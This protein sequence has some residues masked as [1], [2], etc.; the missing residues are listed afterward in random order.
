MPSFTFCTDWFRAAMLAFRPLAMARPAAS[1]APLLMREPEDSWKRGFCRLVLVMLTWFCA[2]SEEMLL[3]MLTDMLVLLFGGPI[4][5]PWIVGSLDRLLSL[6][7][8]S[9]FF[10]PS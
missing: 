7:D 2:I 6:P 1:S 10:S 4:R 3:I 8:L 5:D 9:F